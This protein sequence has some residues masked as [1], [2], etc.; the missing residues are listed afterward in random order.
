MTGDDQE[1]PHEPTQ[2]RLDDARREGQI[3]R[4]Q[5]LLTMAAYGGFLLAAIAFGPAALQEAA[6]IGR[7]FLERPDAPETLM[8]APAM[9]AATLPFLL[10][11]GLCVL[12]LLLAQRGLIFT[13]ANLK[14]RLSR[15]DPI[16]TA[17]H[18]FGPDGLFDFAKS[19]L[20]MAVIGLLLF[21][22]LRG[23]AAEILT[24][25]SLSPGQGLL[26]LLGLLLRFLIFVFALSLVIGALDFL[27]QAFR[28]RLRLRMSRQDLLEEQR[29]SDGDPQAKSTRRQRAQE[30]AMNR[31]LADVP[32]ADVIIVNPTHYAVA[33]HWKRQSRMAPICLAKGV[34]E[35]AHRIRDCAQQH[36]IP[37]HHDPITA[38]ALHATVE[39]GDPIA[40]E[41]YRAVAAALRFAQAMRRKARP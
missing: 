26:W 6:L 21:A 30:I 4:S 24:A 32:K 16:A 14:P 10:M 1:K 9:A 23:E 2:K 36:G 20:K 17:G 3:A 27:W 25:A 13:A 12:L 31:M 29:E 22:L 28:H 35:I 8:A 39:I 40:P 37:I 18:K 19:L 33:L 5:D 38:R 15:I 11:P 7:A 34:D 41:H